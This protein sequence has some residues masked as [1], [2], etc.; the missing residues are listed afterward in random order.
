M[1]S[2]REIALS[3]L[4]AAGSACAQSYSQA[5]TLNGYI[6][7]DDGV[8]QILIFQ[9]AGNAQGGCNTTARFAIDSNAPKFKGTMA[10]VMAAYHTQT[11]VTVVYTQ[12]CNSWTNAWDVGHICVGQLPC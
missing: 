5:G 12:T 2:R 1:K 8:K 10:A 7:F 11:P 9:L 3:L 4:L 6:P